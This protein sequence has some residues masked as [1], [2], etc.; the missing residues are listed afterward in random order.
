MPWRYKRSPEYEHLE[1]R[2]EYRAYD[3]PLSPIMGHAGVVT[4]KSPGFGRELNHVMSSSG[5]VQ[6]PV[7]MCG[8]T[9]RSE[10]CEGLSTD[11]ETLSAP[12]CSQPSELRWRLIEIARRLNHC[13]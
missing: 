6:L 5:D 11:A 7:R 3:L 10:I 8:L 1:Y 9:Q 13:P 2:P 12:C 4:E